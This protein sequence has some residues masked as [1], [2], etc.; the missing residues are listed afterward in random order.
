[1]ADTIC[2]LVQAGSTKH[3]RLTLHL[4]REVSVDAKRK[5]LRRCLDD[6]HLTDDAFL[7]VVIP[8]L[9]PGTLVFVLDRT[10]LGRTDCRREQTRLGR[11]LLPIRTPARTWE[12]GER[13]LN[14]LVLGGVLEGF[15]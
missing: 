4:P 10:F 13:N 7:Q 8:L 14:L 1:M 12:H 3:A 11:L 5:R 2:A 9:P 15:T 6:E